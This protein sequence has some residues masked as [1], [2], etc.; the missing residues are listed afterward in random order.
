MAVL[1]LSSRRVRLARATRAV[2]LAWGTS[3]TSQSSSSLSSLLS[4]KE[5]WK[6]DKE[7]TSEN[8]IT[9]I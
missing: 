2:V 8:A 5:A 1:D 3:M 9:H 6:N 7:G 4:A